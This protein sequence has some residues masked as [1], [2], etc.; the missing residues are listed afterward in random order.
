MR[1]CF[2]PSG[3]TAQRDEDDGRFTTRDGHGLSANLS[4]VCKAVS[5]SVRSK[6]PGFSDAPPVGNLNF[7]SAAPPLAGEAGAVLL[8]DGI[9]KLVA[10]VGHADKL[11]SFGPAPS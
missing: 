1:R 7:M 11:R 5:P 10:G 8:T 6:A 9:F 2:D 3:D 4:A